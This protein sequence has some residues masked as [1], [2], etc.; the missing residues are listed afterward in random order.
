M[1]PFTLMNWHRHA[2]DR[3]DVALHFLLP[4]SWRKHEQRVV[5]NTAGASLIWYG[6]DLK[7]SLPEMSDRG[8]VWVI[9]G[10]TAREVDWDAARLAA[11]RRDCDVLVFDSPQAS[12]RSLYAESVHVDECGQVLGFRRHY[13]DAPV[14]AD[15]WPLA[16][17]LLVCRGRH[18][19]TVV[20]HVVAH[21][22]GPDSIGRL[23]R[24][25]H[26]RWSSGLARRPGGAGPATRRGLNRWKRRGKSAVPVNNAGYTDLL[27]GD[28]GAS[29]LTVRRPALTSEDMSYPRRSNGQPEST[30]TAFGNRSAVAR[31]PVQAPVLAESHEHLSPHGDE[32]GIPWTY[33][34]VKRTMDVLFA[35]TVLGLLSPF[36]L[37]VAC[38]VKLTSRGPVLYGHLRQ[39]HGGREFRCLKFRTMIVGADAMQA[40]LRE[41]NE[42][43]GPQFK[44]SHD[45]RLTA[46]GRWMQR[47][48]IDEIPQFINVL[49][50]EMSL[51][52]PRPSPD[53]EN[54]YCPGWRRARLS[55]RPGITGLW[56][57]LRL[58]NRPDCDFQDWIYYD[59]E[60]ARHRSIWLDCQILVYTPVSMFA[61]HHVAGLA[62]RLAKRRICEHSAWLPQIGSSRIGWVS[63]DTQGDTDRS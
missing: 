31:E 8:D 20:P 32:A 9:N 48:N 51:V 53:K 56:Q 54:Q 19:R 38:A 17:S 13:Q 24:R 41:Q 2:L 10:N 11:R 1:D 3:H 26:V 14:P 60:Y 29:V 4:G 49:R 36:L 6:D 42:V 46:F 58:R 39:G 30:M 35:V 47:Y 59:L 57:V 22:W 23:T 55:V 34:F 45:P 5:S 37:I 7:F 61:H 63:D 25:C 62:R 21:G 15:P 28:D 18:A 16:A 44:L 33:R 43:D 50:G 27:R 12:N 40:R 52:G